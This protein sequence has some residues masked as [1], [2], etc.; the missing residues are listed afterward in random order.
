[1]ATIPIVID[2][3]P[4]QDDAVALLTALASPE[5]DVRAITTVAG[6]IPL[7]LTSRNARMMVDIAGRTDVPVYEGAARPMVRPLVTAEYVHGPTGIDG[8]DVFEP[9]R[10]PAS[11]HAADVI[12][13][14]V[15]AAAPGEVTLCTLGPLTNVAMALVKDP[16]LASR[17]GRLVMMGGGWWEGG[18]VTPAAEFNIYV[19]PHAAHVVFTS[20][21]P[22]T[23]MP[24]DVTHKALTTN[25]RIE[26]FRSL[27]TRAGAVTAGMLDFFDRYDEQKYGTDGGP[28][29]D[30]TVI[31]WLLRPE[32]FQGRD[33]HVA[34]EHASEL[35]MGMTVV[36]WWRVTDRPPN[37][38]VVHDVDAGA[39]FD[40]LVERIGRL[41]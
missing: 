7:E 35:T 24:L 19:D 37:A 1:M 13:D 39:F 38:T 9:S 16:S 18:N 23:M 28:L 14:I 31:A 41:P 2:S 30:P 22:I 10:P 3:D 21:I 5:L 8:V 34:V 4:G 15:S 29:H 26:R 32:I 11:G 36:D 40:L 17:V 6:N 27:G 12:I 20:G 25:A 33:C